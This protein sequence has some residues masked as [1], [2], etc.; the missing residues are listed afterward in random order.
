MKDLQIARHK[1]GVHKAGAKVRNI[2]M[3]LSFE[4][5]YS[6]WMNNGIDKNIP[7]SSLNG[8]QPCMCRKNDIGPYSLDNIYY[9]TRKQNASDNRKYKKYNSGTSCFKII[10][11]PDGIFESRKAAAEYYKV[12]PEAISARVHRNPELYSYI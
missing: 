10:K 8:D 6:W 3:N 12:K 7:N 11:T 1:F 5:W 4:Q 2:E 9:A